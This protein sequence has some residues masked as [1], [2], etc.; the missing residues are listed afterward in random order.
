MD[1]IERELVEDVTRL[2]VRAA[3]LLRGVM[4]KKV[5]QPTLEWG[6]KELAAGE[7]LGR[8]F[9]LLMERPEWVS[10]LNVL[11]L[12]HSLDGQLDFQVREYGLDSL[13]D[14]LQEI[15]VSLQEIGELFDLPQLREAV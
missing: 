4:L 8:Y 7:L 3:V 14:D 1:P 9:P 15:N 13:K 12:V 5:D 11:H 6:L 10:L 2:G